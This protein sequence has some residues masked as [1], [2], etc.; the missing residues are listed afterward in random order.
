M[1]NS[2]AGPVSPPLPDPAFPVVNM[3]LASHTAY[4][5]PGMSPPPA[6][7]DATPARRNGRAPKSTA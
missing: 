6:D 5:H 3:P 7:A 2:P 1:S 4:N